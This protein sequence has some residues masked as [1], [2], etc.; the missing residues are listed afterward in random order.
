MSKSEK[1]YFSTE[2]KRKGENTS[3]YKRLFDEL[4]KMQSY[5]SD[6]LKEKFKGEALAKN[7]AKEKSVLFELLLK[8]IRNYQSQKSEKAKIKESLMNAAL[9]Q[10]RGL[11]EKAQKLWEKAKTQA[12]EIEHYPAILEI[13]P[14]QR[15]AANRLGKKGNEIDLLIEEEKKIISIL[16]H[17]NAISQIFYSHLSIFNQK[18]KVI[19]GEL[20][21]ILKQ[22]INTLE[23]LKKNGLLSFYANVKYLQISGLYNSIN[24]MEKKSIVY[25]RQIVDLWKKNPALINEYNHIYGDHLLNYFSK[26]IAANDF[27]TI[28]EDSIEELRKA[29]TLQPLESAK[30]F[31]DLYNFMLYYYLNMG[32]LEGAVSLVPAIEKGLKKHGPHITI[33]NQIDLINNIASVYFLKENYLL[34]LNW[35]EKQIAK[36]EKLIRQD[37]QRMSRIMRCFIFY[38][39]EQVEKFENCLRGLNRYFRQLGQISFFEQKCLDFLSALKQSTPSSAKNILT[40]FEKTTEQIFIDENVPNPAWLAELLIA[41]RA[42]LTNQ[43]SVSQLLKVLE[44]S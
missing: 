17:E 4:N 19:D 20:N 11:F 31:R 3:N 43:K 2:T 18:S 12:Y 27:S 32:N 39:L 14:K 7:L 5:S 23:E 29:T 21:D 26:C 36:S 22:Q 10:E 28:N 41:V 25:Y 33:T 38:K 16:N 6:D 30:G 13:I 35:L 8:T 1:R 9:L 24:G 37:L 44:S 42:E 40:A 15:S 34:S